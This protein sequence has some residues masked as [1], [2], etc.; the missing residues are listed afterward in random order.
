[1]QDRLIVVFE[2]KSFPDSAE[3]SHFFFKF[4]VVKLKFVK[5]FLYKMFISKYRKSYSSSP[6]DQSGTQCVVCFAPIIQLNVVSKS[7]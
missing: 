1:M 7:Q 3:L 5:L 4:N 6:R 2:P